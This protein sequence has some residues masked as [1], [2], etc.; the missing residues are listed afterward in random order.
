[1]PQRDVAAER[2]QATTQAAIA[3]RTPTSRPR[4]PQYFLS[5]THYRALHPIDCPAPWQADSLHAQEHR[6]PAHGEDCRFEERLF[7][8]NARSTIADP[9]NVAP[10]C[11]RDSLA[12]ESSIH[13]TTAP[14]N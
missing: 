14:P 8:A 9:S 5:T 4:T 12:P 11:S 1:M 6:Q 3:I 13:S 2:P 10:G 7:P